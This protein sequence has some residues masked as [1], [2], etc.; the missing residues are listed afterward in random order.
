MSASRM[1]KELSSEEFQK[2]LQTLEQDLRDN[3]HKPIRL[4]LSDAGLH[5]P[6]LLVS[7]EELRLK[8]LVS[9]VAEKI[10]CNTADSLLTFTA[11]Q[12]NS[13]A[14]LTAFGGALK[15]QS[16]F[17]KS[18]FA[19]VWGAE[20]LKSATEKSLAAMFQPPSDTL[21][22]AFVIES[23]LKQENP[24][25]T[26]SALGSVVHIPPLQADGLK[27]WIVKE[28]QRI[29]VC[30]GIDPHVV[31][32]LS[33]AFENNLSALLNELEKL[34]LLAGKDNTIETKHLQGVSLP[35]QE[36]HSNDLTKSLLRRD[37]LA[38]FDAMFSLLESG[39]HPLQIS[40]QLSKA[41][42]GL[43]AQTG[44]AESLHK[45]VN[46]PWLTRQLGPIPRNHEGELVRSLAILKSLDLSLKDSGLEAEETLA[47]ALLQICRSNENLRVHD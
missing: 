46:V 42:R 12:V 31:D 8:R 44:H 13:A 27:R 34:S 40:A 35:V 19:V 14:G 36:R 11:A 24:L 45:D 37:R 20:K 21:V 38:A 10:G 1:A 30:N 26:L 29:E 16:L 9:H 28:V 33:R 15:T 17:A 43:L 25:S 3:P 39:Q 47:L 7:P 32:L 41:F 22:V 23:P 2:I 4:S 18:Q 5:S 6:L